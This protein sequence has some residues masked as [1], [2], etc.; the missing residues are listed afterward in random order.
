[1]GGGYSLQWT[2]RGSLGGSAQTGIFCQDVGIWKG[3]GLTIWSIPQGCKSVI[4][5]YGGGG[6]LPTVDYKG[7]I[8]RLCPNGYL[9]SG[10]RYMEG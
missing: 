1:M 7:I 8:G 5:E 10:C 2:L 3:R 4:W 6:L 9:L